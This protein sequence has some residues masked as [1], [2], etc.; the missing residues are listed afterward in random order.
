M[1]A[2]GIVYCSYNVIH[3]ICEWTL[4]WILEY[5]FIFP[6]LWGS[7][8]II[9]FS[10]YVH[11]R[12]YSISSISG[13]ALSCL[14]RKNCEG[15]SEKPI[16]L[17]YN[18]ACFKWNPEKGAKVDYYV[19]VHYSEYMYTFR[20]GEFSLGMNSLATNV[21]FMGRFVWFLIPS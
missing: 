16:D 9:I 11:I 10:C 6:V 18:A 3:A 4:E 15:L 20:E 5:G 14:D 21:Y 17:A 8:T 19:H 7:D 13:F 12:K 2:V 1:C